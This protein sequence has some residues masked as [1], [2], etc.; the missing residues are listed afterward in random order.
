MGGSRPA[1]WRLLITVGVALAAVA[2]IVPVRWAASAHA[3]SSTGST[4]VPA[5]APTRVLDTRDPGQTRLP[6]NGTLTLQV[7]GVP[8]RATAVVLNVTAVAPTTGGFL[9]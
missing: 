5:L 3:T 1:R 9:A 7:P 2:V 6:A 4:Y 8:A